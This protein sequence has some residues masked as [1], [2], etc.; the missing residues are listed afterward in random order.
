MI[1]NKEIYLKR[2]DEYINITEYD[3]S[4][5]EK[6]I[7][8]KYLLNKEG[9]ILEGGIGTGRIIFNLKKIGFKKLYGFDYLPE[10]ISYA[11][12]YAKRMKYNVNFSIADAINLN[13]YKSET[14]DYTIYLRNFISFI[15]HQY[16][17]QALKEAYRALKKN[18]IALF[19]FLNIEG[20]WYNKFIGIIVNIVR[21]FS[22]YEINMHILPWL[23]TKK[24]C[25]NWKF[26]FMNQA[27]VYWFDKGE[28]I[29]LLQ[30][31]GYKIVEV[32]TEKE[33]LDDNKREQGSIYIV[34]KK[35]N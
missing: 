28:I 25:F 34:C 16:T 35:E 14:F 9:K 7:I 17:R 27:Q 18:G 5:P 10:M 23:S 4:V 6:Y 2:K 1:T 22:G 13:C 21:C 32:K 20:R 15:P 29:G 24:H 11:N 3:L 12:S 30:D 8:I 31:V 19:S 26:L 33:I